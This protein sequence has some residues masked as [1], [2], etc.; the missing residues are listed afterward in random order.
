MEFV[1]VAAAR[2]DEYG[3]GPARRLRRQEKIPAVAYGKELESVSLAVSP[4]DI[5]DVLHGEFGRNT[6]IE[7]DVEGA[8]KSTVLLSEFQY[9]PVTRELLHADFRQI[10]MDRTVQVEVPF[11]LTGRSRGVVAGG[12]LRQVFRKLPISCLPAQIPAR[13][14]YDVTEL[15]VDQ[16]VSIGALT[17]PEGVRVSLPESQTVAGVASVTEAPSTEEEEKA[18]EEGAEAAAGEQPA[19][20]GGERPRAGEQKPGT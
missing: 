20:G 2:R 19:E 11:E 4:K 18:A 1:K 13:I 14:E 17:L 6:V 10:R 5:L 7:L 15:D 8:N 16:H 12:I 3:K 9:H